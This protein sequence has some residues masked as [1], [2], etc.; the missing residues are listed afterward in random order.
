MKINRLRD[1][2]R[3]IKE[4]LYFK[5]FDMFKAFFLVV[6]LLRGG[7]GGGKGQTTKEKELF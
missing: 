4:L 6:R 5:M 2:T 1:N 3:I 7:G